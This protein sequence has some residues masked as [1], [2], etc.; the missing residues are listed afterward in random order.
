VFEC[1]HFENGRE[2]YLNAWG[3]F[4]K[5]VKMKPKHRKM[6]HIKHAK[7][8][9]LEENVLIFGDLHLCYGKYKQTLFNYT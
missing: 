3:N 1:P 5:E 2:A 8:N 7:V 9:A 4:H 6:H